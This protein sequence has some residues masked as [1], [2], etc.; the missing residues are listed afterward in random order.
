MGIV[1]WRK[2]A[3]TL[4]TASNAALVECGLCESV[5]EQAGP[6]PVRSGGVG[7]SGF[8]SEYIGYLGFLEI[9]SDIVLF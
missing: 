1:A 2:K 3:G 5:C 7:R 9:R 4:R 8:H 6:D